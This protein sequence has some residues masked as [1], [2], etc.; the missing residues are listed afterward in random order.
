MASNQSQTAAKA[1]TP[2][3]IAMPTNMAANNAHFTSEGQAV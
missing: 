2:I 1:Y 3:R